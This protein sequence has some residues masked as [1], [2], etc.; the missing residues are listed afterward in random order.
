M[1]ALDYFLK[2]NLYGLLFASCYWLL[3]RRHT[4]FGLNRAYLLVSVLLTL[5]LPLVSLPTQTVEE[6]PVPT[7]VLTIPLATPPAVE[8]SPSVA[9]TGLDWEL[10][11]RLAYALVAFGLLTRLIIQ[12]RSLLLLIRRAPRQVRDGYTL[13]EINDAT[14]PT[15]SFFRFIILNPAD[16]ANDQILKH[17][18]IHVRQQHSIDVMSLALLRIVFWACP[19]LWLLDRMLRQVHEFTADQHADQ[20]TRYAHFLVE[21]SFGLQPSPLTNGFFNP[22]LLKQRI[23]MLH[24]QATTRWALGKYVLILPLALTLL[25]MT[26]AQKQIEAVVHQ[27]TD[28]TITVSGRVTNVLGKPLVGSHVG[29]GSTGKGTITDRNGYY[30]IANVPKSSQL[31]YSYLGYRTD[32]LRLDAL[33]HRIRRNTLTMNHTLTAIMEDELPAMGATAMYRAIKPNPAMPLVTPP[34]SQTINGKVYTAVEE[35]A[36]FPTG[37]PGLMQY[38]AHNLRYPAKAKAA[39]IEGDVYVLF[40]VLPTGA[41][42]E[43]SV[44]KNMARIGGGCEEEAMRVVSRMPNWI[45]AKQNGKAV[46]VRYQLPIR[47]ALEKNEDKRTGQLNTGDPAHKP[48]VS[49]STPPDTG[50]KQASTITIRGRGPLGQLGPGP[51]YILDGVEV[52]GDTLASM[53]RK[54]INSIDALRDASAIAQYGE[55]GRNGVVIIT[56]KKQ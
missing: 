42:S 50:R 34:S 39:G 29:V 25:A 5:A 12:I 47:F 21:Y 22:S 56:T 27:A 53:D 35:K 17:E 30:T 24:R 36:I 9:E 19:A 13:V 28:E 38:V 4:F 45:P 31:A 40:T 26:T 1:T 41:I 51:L 46:A 33:S 52:S 32:V 43:A 6:L 48:I 49:F 2:A 16:R 23:Q 15:F 54:T 10:W 8:A 14:T 18:L 20:P 44:N 37:I 3:L 11:G 7:G 55:K